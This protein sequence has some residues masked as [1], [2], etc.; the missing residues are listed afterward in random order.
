VPLPD[1]DKHL[2]YRVISSTIQNRIAYGCF[3]TAIT[4]AARRTEVSRLPGSRRVKGDTDPALQSFPHPHMTINAASILRA[5]S[6]SD[7]TVF[8][9]LL[10]NSQPCKQIGIEELKMLATAG[11]VC[12]K[13]RGGRIRSVQLV[14]PSSVAFAEV[15]KTVRS[16]FTSQA[17]QTTERASQTLPSYVRRHHPAHCSA[18]AGMTPGF[19]RGA[20]IDQA[21]V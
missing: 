19:A 20:A 6:S 9:L 16:A 12:A 8:S 10:E 13:W 3:R 18:W 2:T 7:E 17:S 14:V 4:E 15:R 21:S 5:V 11:H 1:Y